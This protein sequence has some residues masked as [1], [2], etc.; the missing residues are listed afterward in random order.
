ML[1]YC[2]ECFHEIIDASSIIAPLIQIASIIIASFALGIAWK[3]LGGVKK[4]QALQAQMNI[5]SL[6]NEFIKNQMQYK[7]VVDQYSKSNPQDIDDMNIKKVNAFELYIT[8]ADKLASLINANYL[9]YQFPKRDWKSEYIEI[10]QKV[11]I[12]HQGEDSIIPGKDQMIR[13]INIILL[14][15]NKSK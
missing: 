8:S 1:L 13:N 4:S 11:K 14:K 5:I 9:Q 10:F 12:Y 3:N 6:E 2:R 7:M 15:W